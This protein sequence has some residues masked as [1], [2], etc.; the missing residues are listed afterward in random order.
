MHPHG[1]ALRRFGTAATDLDVAFG[2]CPDDVQATEVLARCSGADATC[3]Q[4]W[5]LPRRLQALLAVRCGPHADDQETCTPATLACPACTARFEIELPLARCRQPV[6]D[7]PL[8]LRTATGTPLLV[9]LPT[10]DDLLAWRG[11]PQP[12]EA[13]LAAQ[14]LLEVD[15]R[16]PAA[17]FV[18]DPE[19]VAAVAEALAA[20]DPCTVLPVQA[21]CPECGHTQEADI[22][23]QALLLR[24]LAAQQRRLLAEVTAL[25][26]AFHWS[27]A[28]IL[29]LPA[30]RRAHYLASIE[31]AGALA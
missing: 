16:A 27:E 14:L 28:Q 15:G 2:A 5:T 17:G 7:T 19:L 21:A 13:A 22:D 12:D 29:A 18:P 8:P 6:D 25:A 4:G 11:L 3:V 10:G 1:H 23:L 26:R 20:R 24:D 31:S 30:W 9:R